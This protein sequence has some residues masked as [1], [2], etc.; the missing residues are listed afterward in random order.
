LLF[1]F[2]KVNERNES[3]K[4]KIPRLRVVLGPSWPIFHHFPLVFA[5]L[6]SERISSRACRWEPFEPPW[7]NLKVWLLRLWD[8]NADRKALEYALESRKKEM[9]L[10][11]FGIKKPASDITDGPTHTC[12]KCWALFTHSF[13]SR[14]CVLWP[15][16]T[17][18]LMDY[19]ISLFW[20]SV[21]C[22]IFLSIPFQGGY[23]FVFLFS[24]FQEMEFFHLV[25]L[26]CNLTISIHILPLRSGPTSSTG[27][28]EFKVQ[29]RSHRD[30]CRKLDL[31][32]LRGGHFSLLT[33]C[34]AG[35]I[36]SYPKFAMARGG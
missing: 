21:C 16:G 5:R 4:A 33:F 31:P 13:P 22:T 10:V 6:L 29:P 3:L 1:V 30:V 24:L 18:A 28:N 14:L 9:C 36:V 25:R 20:N 2:M 27:E 34:L 17:A 35:Q 8:R 23:L 19:F 11:Y 26:N 32:S 15:Y 7:W 12:I